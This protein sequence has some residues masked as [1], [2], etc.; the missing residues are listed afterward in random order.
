MKVCVDNFWEER[1]KKKGGKAKRGGRRWAGEGGD[2]VGD[3]SVAQINR[4]EEK[5]SGCLKRKGRMTA[6]KGKGKERV[7]CRISLTKK[8]KGRVHRKM[9]GNKATFLGRCCL[10]ER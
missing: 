5:K 10:T 4:W 7:C 8:L 9:L 2:Y 6:G 1:R 3:V